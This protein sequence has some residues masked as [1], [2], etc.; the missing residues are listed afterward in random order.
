LFSTVS[1]SFLLLFVGCGFVQERIWMEKERSCIAA[2]SS[3]V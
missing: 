1:V 2:W 3:K